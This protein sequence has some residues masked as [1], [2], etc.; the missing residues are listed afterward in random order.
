MSSEEFSV[1]FRRALQK[2]CRNGDLNYAEFDNLNNNPE[3]TAKVYDAA[4]DLKAEAETKKSFNSNTME[5]FI[6]EAI[7]VEFVERKWIVL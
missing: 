6:G 4:L 2:I 7:L 1:Q 5:D 3:F